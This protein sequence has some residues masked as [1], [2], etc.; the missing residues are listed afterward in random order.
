MNCQS[1]IVIF[2]LIVLNVLGENPEEG[3]NRNLVEPHDNLRESS[4]S[5]DSSGTNPEHD[6]SSGQASASSAWHSAGDGKLC[7]SG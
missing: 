1:E 3:S 6:Q 4:E 7:A 2:S 5:N